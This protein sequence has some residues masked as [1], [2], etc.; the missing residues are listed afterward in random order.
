MNLINYTSNGLNQFYSDARFSGID[1]QG[2]TIAVIDM[3][4]NLNHAGFGEDRNRDGLKDVFPRKD[5]DFTS[6]RNSVNDGTLHGMWVSSVAYSVAKGI[7]ILPIQVNTVGQAADTM[8]WISQNKERYGISAVNISLSDGMNTTNSLPSGIT[9]SFYTSVGKAE[10]QGITVVAAAGNSYQGYNIPGSSGIAGLNNV[11]GVMSTGGNGLTESTSL[12]NTSQ[13]R[14]DLIGAPGSGIP[15]FHGT[16]SVT[17]GA[18]TSF[19]SPFVVGSVALLQG[20]AERYLHRSLTPSEM[21]NLLEQTDTT[22]TGTPGGYEQINV[23]N[24]AD[25]LY[26][27]GTGASP[28]TLRDGLLTDQSY[29]PSNT[30]TR[31]SESLMGGY[32]FD[33]LTGN[34]TTASTFRGGVGSDLLVGGV[35][36]NTFAYSNISEGADEIL[37]F[38]PGKDKIDISRLLDGIGYDGNNPLRDR[39]VRVGVSEVTNSVISIDR[40]GLGC[41]QPQVLATLVNTNPCL[42]N[43]LNNFIL[44]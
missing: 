8:D 44:N 19:A 7:N 9:E 37:K 35:G 3:G 38:T 5:L 31:Y 41:G 30:P 28:N 11:I 23:Y 16:N 13:R 4:F 2:Q 33:V 6:S 34:S 21:K 18:G 39:V 1:G 22:L 42:I 12:R 32:Y 17:R 27:I 14:T 36:K 20:V 40:D 15:V 26:D 24:A 10:S 43:N 25:L 29:M